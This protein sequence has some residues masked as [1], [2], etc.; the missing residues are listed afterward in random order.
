[1]AKPGM[2]RQ[3]TPATM[4]TTAYTQPGYVTFW[5]L[6]NSSWGESGSEQPAG[7]PSGQLPLPLGQ[8]LA[9]VGGGELRPQAPHPTGARPPLRPP[10]AP[11]LT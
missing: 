4:T 11:G 1:M 2:T 7:S 8:F 5:D 9:L 3:G 10:A 6:G